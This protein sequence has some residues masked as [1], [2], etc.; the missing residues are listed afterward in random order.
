MYVRKKVPD[1]KWNT[2][3]NKEYTEILR[4][5]PVNYENV[6]FLYFFEFDNNGFEHLF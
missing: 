5:I 2:E 6:D 4:Q 1:S 3:K